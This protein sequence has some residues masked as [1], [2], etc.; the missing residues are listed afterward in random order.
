MKLA[1]KGD[2]QH[3][4]HW[5]G[6][7]LLSVPSKIFCRVLLNIINRAIDVKL[8][9]EQA[10]FQRGKDVQIRY[11]PSATSLNRVLNGMHHYV[12]VS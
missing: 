1:K 3:C 4:D 9:Q 6:I 2:L 5:R 8:R 10:G 12:L 11:S 7:T